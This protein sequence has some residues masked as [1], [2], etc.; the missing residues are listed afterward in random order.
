[1][2]SSIPAL[3]DYGE[4]VCGACMHK[5]TFLWHYKKE[6]SDD[7][8][9]IKAETCNGTVENCVTP[10]DIKIEDIRSQTV[11]LEDRGKSIVCVMQCIT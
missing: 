6:T 7:S 2:G 8:E 9:Q 4:M 11:K 5:H 1:L 3:H 10:N